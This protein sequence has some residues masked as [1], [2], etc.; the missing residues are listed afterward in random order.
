MLM[1]L[2]LRHAHGRGAQRLLAQA[3]HARDR[4]AP[5]AQ[6]ACHLVTQVYERERFFLARH[7]FHGVGAA[8]GLAECCVQ[9]SLNALFCPHPRMMDHCA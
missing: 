3:H 6:L 2:A 4:A 9:V 7:E 5:S 8:D 1:V